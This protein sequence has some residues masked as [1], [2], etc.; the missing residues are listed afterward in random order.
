MK[1]IINLNCDLDT[2]LREYAQ[3]YLDGKIDFVEFMEY[4]ADLMADAQRQNVM[5]LKTL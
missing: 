5:T 2:L 3:Q 4:S 1:N